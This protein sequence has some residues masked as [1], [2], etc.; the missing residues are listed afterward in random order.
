MDSMFPDQNFLKRLTEKHELAHIQQTPNSEARKPFRK[1]PQ[2]SGRA[3]PL[4][5]KGPKFNP[6]V[7]QRKKIPSLKQTC[8]IYRSIL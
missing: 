5:G 7:W 1:H 6:Q 2:L 4:H 8:P 3:M